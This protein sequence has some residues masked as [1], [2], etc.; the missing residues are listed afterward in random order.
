MF[1]ECVLKDKPTVQA[2]RKVVAE[3]PDT[4]GLSKTWSNGIDCL[5]FFVNKFAHSFAKDHMKTMK[6][7][8]LLEQLEK[9]SAELVAAQELQ[10]RVGVEA[11]S[12]AA[13]SSVA[14]SSAAASSAPVTRKRRRR[15]TSRSGSTRRTSRRRRTDSGEY[16]T[17]APHSEPA[18]A[19]RQPSQRTQRRPERLQNGAS[20]DIL[21]DEVGVDDEDYEHGDSDSEYDDEECE[22][23]E[24]E[25]IPVDLSF[26]LELELPTG[27]SG[28]TSFRDNPEGMT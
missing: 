3:V 2:F 8:R 7:V 1:A 16:T 10:L 26:F 18:P 23:G 20:V 17:S 4:E 19:E 13:A 14:A 5:F 9:K 24:G 25:E 6:S 21:D 11:A 22:E 28:P 12:S 27:G 15:P